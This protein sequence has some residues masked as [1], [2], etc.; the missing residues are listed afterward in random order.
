MVPF[1]DFINHH[2]VD[3]SYELRSRNYCP[4]TNEKEGMPE[5]YFTVS[6][7]EINYKDFFYPKAS[8]ADNNT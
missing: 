5:A 7:K 6:K 8:D 2:N 4:N 3:S 1:A